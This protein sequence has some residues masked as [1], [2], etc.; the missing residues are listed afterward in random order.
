MRD[1]GIIDD[2]TFFELYNQYQ[3]SIPSSGQSGSGGDYYR[4]KQ[5]KLGSV[6]SDA[7]WSA[8]NTGFVSYRDAYE[9][10]GVFEAASNQPHI[11]LH[12]TQ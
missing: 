7:I 4:N 8:V 10:T 12:Y 2:R 5:Y 9:L 11:H 3:T 6:F 1:V